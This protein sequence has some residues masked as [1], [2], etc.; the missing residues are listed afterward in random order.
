MTFAIKDKFYFY[1]YAIKYNIDLVKDYVQRKAAA[2]FT[3]YP[4]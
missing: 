2:F 4:F 1:K 3:K